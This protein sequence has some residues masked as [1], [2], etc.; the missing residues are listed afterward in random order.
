MK[1]LVVADR[2]LVEGKSC[3]PTA[4]LAEDGAI[5]RPVNNFRFNESPVQMLGKCD[6]LTASVVSPEGNLRVPA[7]R[8]HEFN[9]ASISEAV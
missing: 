7:L 5:T 8:T 9:L 3:G 4:V 1:T 2:A 6:G